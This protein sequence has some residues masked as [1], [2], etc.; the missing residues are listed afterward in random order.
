[1]QYKWR[2]AI[3][4]AL[5]L[6]MAILDN[7]IV[8]VALTYM[9]QDFHTDQ[10]TI[11]W[12]I[13]GYFLSQ[14]AVIPVVGYLSDRIGTKTVFLMALALFTLGSGLCALAP[15]EGFLIACRVVQGLG[16]GAI[17]PV[18]FAI[19]FR[20]FPPAERGPASALI[21]VP[22]LLAPVF[23]PTIGGLLTTYF[24]WRAIFTVN[25]PIGVVVFILG[26]LTL[27]GH[28]KEAAM[29]DEVPAGMQ[30]GF[31]VIGLLLAV[32]GTVALVYGINQSANTSFTDQGVWPFIAGGGV[33]LLA[34]II[35]ELRQSDPVMDM[36]LFTNYRFA[37]ANLLTW[38]LSAFLFGSL[39]FLPVFFEQVQGRD[40]LNTG[41]ILGVQGIASI[42][43]VI[44]AGLLYNRIGPRPILLV[45]FV[46]ITGATIGFI[47]LAPNTDPAALIPWLAVRGLGFGL[48]NIPLQTLAVATISNRAMARASSLLNVT[49]QIF[50]AVGLTLLTAYFTNQ[51]TS[52]ATDLGTAY[53]TANSTT[54]QAQC[55]AQV[56]F[57]PSAIHACFAQAVKTYVQQPTVQQQF[58]TSALNDTFFVVMIGTGIAAL[59]SIFAGRDPNVQK[60]K[61]DARR[62]KNGEAPLPAPEGTEERRPA[63]IGE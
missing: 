10:N 31:D 4:V 30:K 50:S 15:N 6:F 55:V 2:A 63:L 3:I 24:S 42:V 53:A 26:I 39:F 22:V 35:Y 17:F 37:V 32:A 27:R 59:V 38:M 62:A 8:N 23:G 12:V 52:H 11:S 40:A 7:T 1:M 29:G 33:L 19:A 46:L 25:L 48:T 13:T 45:G 43:S 20:V 5:G 16:G 54:L 28:A 14:A 61:A 49:R 60:L 58:L 36:R 41:L 34:F 56:G 44:A 47:N 9:K 57:N 51:A 21:S 18:A